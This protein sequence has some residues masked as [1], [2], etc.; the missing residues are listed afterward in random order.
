[1]YAIGSNESTAR[2]CG[3]PIRTTKILV[4]TI[5]GIFTGLAGVMEFSKLNIGQRPVR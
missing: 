1:M 4:Y 5:A 3:V 2:L